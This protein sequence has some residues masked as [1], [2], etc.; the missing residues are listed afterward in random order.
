MIDLPE[1]SSKERFLKEIEGLKLTT[2]TLTG[3]YKKKD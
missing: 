2:A 1:G 3:I